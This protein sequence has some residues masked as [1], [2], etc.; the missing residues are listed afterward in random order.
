MSPAD[1]NA[2]H[3]LRVQRRIAPHIRRAPLVRSAYLS[4]RSSADVWL[5]LECR[6]PTGSFKV[7]G[8]LNKLGRLDAGQKARGIVT[9]SA[10][11]HGLGVAYAASRLGL[12]RVTVF[13]PENAPRS[14]LEKLGRFPIDL[15]RAGH[16]YEA[17]HDAATAFADETG[18]AYISAYD[19]L[20]I[21]A[22]QGTCGL[23]ILTDLPQL[24]TIFVPVGGGGLIAGVAVA[25]KAL[26]PGCRV[27]GLQPEASPAARQSFEQNWPVE[28]YRAG[29]TLADGLAGGF[30]AL[31]FYLARTLI[32]DIWLHSE[33]DLRRA[34]FTLVDQEQLVV[35]ASGAIAV[36]PLLDPQRPLVGQT[37]ACVLTGANID[38]RV[39]GD[40]L[41][42]FG[43]ER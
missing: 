17:A 30:G 1:L 18:A 9:A 12:S 37:V 22:G 4:Q 27:I 25:A 2:N 38:S 5:K 28:R 7:R 26:H 36:A 16:S 10:G 8:A 21:I 3:I 20:D 35:E 11:N 24:D 23:E 34:I 33:E 15:R 19:D 40:I 31:P 29:P 42:E 6:Q 39:L 41:R 32:D 14:K 43:G 13:V